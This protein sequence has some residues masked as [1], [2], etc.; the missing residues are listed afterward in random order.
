MNFTGV[1]LEIEFG[2]LPHPL[3]RQPQGQAR[4]STLSQRLL[5]RLRRDAD[6]RLDG[7]Q[8]KTHPGDM[9]DK[10]LYDL[11]PEELTDIPAHCARHWANCATITPSC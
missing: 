7:I 5:S 2:V 9:M 8:N 6:G 3:C 4:R 11:P 10:N 1:Y